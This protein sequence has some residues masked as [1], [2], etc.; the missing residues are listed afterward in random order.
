M[1]F[2]LSRWGDG[3]IHLYHEDS[4]SGKDIDIVLDCIHPCASGKQV[5][6]CHFLRSLIIDLEVRA[7]ADQIG[8]GASQN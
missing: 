4:L 8:K 2:E 7:H 5:D 3:Q 6:V 1:D